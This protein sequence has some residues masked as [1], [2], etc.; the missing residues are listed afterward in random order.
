[1]S[2]S[3]ENDGITARIRSFS[4]IFLVDVEASSTFLCSALEL[5]YKGL[6][7]ELIAEL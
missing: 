3:G 7:G 1:M 6:S 5:T 2:D 4:K